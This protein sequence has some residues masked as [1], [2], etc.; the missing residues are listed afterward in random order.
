[1]TTHV[2]LKIKIEELD[3]QTV[4]GVSKEFILSGYANGVAHNVTF[5]D[6]ITCLRET[7]KLL[8]RWE[9]IVNIIEKDTKK[10]LK[11]SKIITRP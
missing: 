2:D 7:K 6:P 10:R 11:T 8:K 1:M 5:T 3:L 9:N 4:H